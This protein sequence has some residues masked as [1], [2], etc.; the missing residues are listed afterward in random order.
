[1][2]TTKKPSNPSSGEG[3]S[4]TRKVRAI[5]ASPAASKA[6][7]RKKR[8]PGKATAHVPASFNLESKSPLAEPVI[9][10]DQ[11]SLRAYFI[12][13]RRQQMGWPG[14]PSTDW[15]DAEAQLRAEALEKPLKKR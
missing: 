3:K 2:A 11:I 5:K 10:H 15:A 1:M 13:E 4:T 7:S 12:A 6:P 9:P 14:D 8:A